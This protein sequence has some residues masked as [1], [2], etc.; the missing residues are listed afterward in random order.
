M[1][2]CWW[3]WTTA[4]SC[5]SGCSPMASSRGLRAGP[6]PGFHGG[7]VFCTPGRDANEPNAGPS[8]T[9]PELVVVAPVEVVEPP[10]PPPQPATRTMVDRMA[11]RRMIGSVFAVLAL[12]FAATA[13]AAEADRLA[14]ARTF[15]LALGDGAASRDLSQYDLVVVDGGISAKRVAAIRASGPLVLGY[16]SVGTIEPGRSWFAAAKPYRLDYW[17]DWGEWYADVSK[18]GFRDLIL[19]RGAPA[20]MRPGVAGRCPPN[21]P[22]IARPPPP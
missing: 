2:R 19:R 16:L 4:P 22:T 13:E 14:G 12:V 21:P 3:M 10:L 15:A 11:R 17:D 8:R 5:D 9:P 7:G 18:P 1:S 6:L 20:G